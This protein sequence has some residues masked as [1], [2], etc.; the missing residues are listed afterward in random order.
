MSYTTQD[1]LYLVGSIVAVIVWLVR[2]EGKVGANREAVCRLEQQLSLL[3]K[4]SE[5]VARI[6]GKLDT[7]NTNGCEFQKRCAATRPKD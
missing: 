3:T 5:T 7:I 6:E 2:L 4:L 1:L